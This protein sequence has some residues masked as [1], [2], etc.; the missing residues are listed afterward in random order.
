MFSIKREAD[1]GSTARTRLHLAISSLK[2]SAKLL[3]AQ[4][5]IGGA[6]LLE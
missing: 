3:A 2:G 1:I 6:S 5:E 4:V